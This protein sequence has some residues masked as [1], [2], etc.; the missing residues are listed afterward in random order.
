MLLVMGPCRK[1]MCVLQEPDVSR[2]PEPE[3]EMLF[4]SIVFPEPSTTKLSIV[5]SSKGETFTGFS[6]AITEQAMRGG[7]G[8]GS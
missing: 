4:F 2:T 6:S 8:A 1:K 5:Y 7:Y 3:R